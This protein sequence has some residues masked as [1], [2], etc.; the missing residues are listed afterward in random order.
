M[1]DEKAVFYVFVESLT[2][3]RRSWRCPGQSSRVSDRGWDERPLP[4]GDKTW[5]AGH[6]LTGGR[7]AETTPKHVRRHH[8]SAVSDVNMNSYES[9]PCIERPST[10]LWSACQK[11]YCMAV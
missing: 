6:E 9:E 3:T 2:V 5:R 1:T 11:Q 7:R 8:R 4:D 10:C